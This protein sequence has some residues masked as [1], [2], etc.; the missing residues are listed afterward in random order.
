MGQVVVTTGQVVSTMGPVV[1]AAA[2]A[3]TGFAAGAAARVE[4]SD[5]S[6]AALRVF[7]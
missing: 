3:A 4:P 2:L 7:A 6:S 5:R 1:A